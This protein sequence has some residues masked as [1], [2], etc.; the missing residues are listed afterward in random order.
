[1]SYIWMLGNIAQDSFL[2][3]RTKGNER[4]KKTSIATPSQACLSALNDL[5]CTPSIYSRAWLL[6]ADQTTLR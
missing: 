1:M 2:S 3:T 5:E 6:L 4:Q